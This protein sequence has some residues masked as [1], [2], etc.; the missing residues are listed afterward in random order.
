MPLYETPRGAIWAAD[1]RKDGQP[2]LIL[3]HGAGGSHLDWAGAVRKL[4]TVALDLPGHGKST[5]SGRDSVAEYAADVVALLD[6]LGLERAVMG[7]HSMGG[8]IAQTLALDYPQRVQ[9][10]ILV[11]TG[12]KLS[13][14]PDIL[15]RVIEH[16]A[17]VGA[18]LKAWMWSPDTA[19][20]AREIGFQQFM[21][22]DPRVV[23][24]DYLACNRFDV[25]DRI[26]QISAPTLIIGGT[27]DRMTPLKYSQFLAER[28]RN[29]HMV[30]L[31]GAGHMMLLEQPES[32][33]AQIQA[34]LAAL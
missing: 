22:V 13:V 18:L 23:H 6:A 29:A 11:G 34:W 31:E 25:R 21:T 26:A 7:G 32:A 15:D 5:A 1:Q 8:A 27:A 24:G 2:P 19:D 16:Q 12:A 20:E 4:G 9:G 17:E 33:A 30:T 14:H 3:I 10:L 28:I